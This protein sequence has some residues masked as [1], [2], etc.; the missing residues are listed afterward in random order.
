MYSNINSMNNSNRPKII[1]IKT[2]KKSN[3]TKV[4]VRHCKILLNYIKENEHEFKD[5][6]YSKDETNEDGSKYTY[7]TYKKSIITFLEKMVKQNGK[8]KITY[9]HAKNQ[10]QG[11]EYTTEFTLQNCQRN[12]KGFL[13]QDI[14]ATDYDIVNCHYTELLYYANKHELDCKHLKAYVNDRAGFLERN[15]QTKKSMLV[16]LNCDTVKG[17]YNKEMKQF[18]NQLEEIKEELL[19]LYPDIETTNDK[20]PNSSKINK[21][22]CIK[23]N[24]HVDKVIRHFNVKSSLKFFDGFIKWGSTKLD[25]N[26]LNKLTEEDGI[27][28]TTKEFETLHIENPNDEYEIIDEEAYNKAYQEKKNEFEKKHFMIENPI[29]Y[30]REETDG[31]IS[32]YNK[33]DFAD[34][35]AT[36]QIKGRDG[37]PISLFNEWLTDETRR[38][39]KKFDLQPYNRDIKEPEDKDGIYNLFTE[40]P[41]RYDE[42]NTT[43]IS[44]F[45]EFMKKL[46][47]YKEKREFIL[48]YFAHL[49]Q[50][51]GKQCGIM[52]YLIGLEGAG[53][54]TLLNYII[55]PLIGHA[56]YKECDNLDDVTGTFNSIIA[57]KLFIVINEMSSAQGIN[58]KDRLKSIVDAPKI[59]INE[60][61]KKQ[62]TE[63]NYKRFMG[64]SNNSGALCADRGN[65][66]YIECKTGGIMKLEQKKDFD[67]ALLTQIY[68]RV[69]TDGWLQA[70]YNYFVKFDITDFDPRKDGQSLVAINQTDDTPLYAFMNSI[71]I[72][73]VFQTDDE[74]CYYICKNKF[75]DMY[76][77]WITENEPD[78]QLH[79]EKMYKK[80][81]KKM[82][83]KLLSGKL[84]FETNTRKRKMIN[85]ER[86]YVYSIDRDLMDEYKAALESLL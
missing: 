31:T 56:N 25:I 32:Q 16:I 12:I 8:Q 29:T 49:I 72:C 85:N 7:S 50:H 28:W 73:D 2:P 70:V 48:K 81:N 17:R 54:G 77:E 69:K 46:L 47:P 62:Y 11:R 37:Q 35:T 43:D 40:F 19:T 21:L 74:D 53:K 80:V 45:H 64:A 84:H 75:Q 76:E 52:P 20:N 27:K 68:K 5:Q 3:S 60:K 58:H 78:F 23:E 66:R 6:I 9:K 65:R 10:T 79:D 34:L 38:S 57:E 82:N 41:Y 15:K 86:V 61:G 13:L 59:T 55:Q 44:D 71:D 14:D 83:F 18:I 22:L 24:E 1:K 63:T 33:R 51:P 4:N 30:C 42:T 36:F 67:N 26:E 39:Y